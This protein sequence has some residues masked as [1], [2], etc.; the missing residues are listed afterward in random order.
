MGGYYDE[1]E[2]VSFALGPWE[3]YL[4]G[5]DG[6]DSR[7]RLTDFLLQV[8]ILQVLIVGWKIMCQ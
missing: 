7:F 2:V 1:G 8:A 3:C 6:L 4:F 5:A